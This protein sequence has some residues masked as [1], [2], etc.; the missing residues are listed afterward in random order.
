MNKHT[1]RSAALPVIAGIVAVVSLCGAFALNTN[2]EHKATPQRIAVQQTT[3]SL[4]VAIPK[5]TETEVQTIL[6]VKEPVVIQGSA[7]LHVSIP[8]V[9]IDAKVSG[10]TVP[11]QTDNC[12][13]T[14]LCID[15]PVSDQA[16]WYGE[17]PSMP[18]TNP[19]LL[20]AHTSWSTASF[21]TFNNLPAVIAGDEIVVTTETGVFTYTAEAP[22]FVAYN[23]I[24]QSETVY[25]HA[26]EK[27]VLVT[28]NAAE[29]AAT[30]VVGRLVKAIAR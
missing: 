4:E 3:S 16:A 18:S 14:E 29:S 23:D 27:V 9:S 6:P 17:V 28:C 21:A 15:P 10:E 20:F 13:A 7:I 22:T 30:V 5:P 12:H 19:V 8:A 11:R 1:W 2:G 24:A 26:T 25:G